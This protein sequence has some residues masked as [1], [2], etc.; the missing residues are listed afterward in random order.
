[1][2][3]LGTHF[4]LFAKGILVYSELSS[5]VRYE[6]QLVLAKKLP[7]VILWVDRGFFPACTSRFD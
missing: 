6:Q 2:P 5:Q 7:V 3:R 1:M 4:L